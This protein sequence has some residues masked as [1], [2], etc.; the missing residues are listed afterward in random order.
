MSPHIFLSNSHGEDKVLVRATMNRKEEM[1]R[2]T[3]GTQMKG[4]YKHTDRERKRERRC[5]A[6]QKVD[7]GT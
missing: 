6:F 5:C 2:S 4:S 3:L 1:V 7:G